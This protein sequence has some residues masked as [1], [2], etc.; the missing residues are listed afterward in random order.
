MPDTTREVLKE[1]LKEKQEEEERLASSEFDILANIN[2]ELKCIS[3]LLT[4]LIQ[5]L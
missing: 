4:V 3:K 2:N 1:I 5:K